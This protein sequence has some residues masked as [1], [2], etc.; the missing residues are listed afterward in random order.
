MPTPKTPKSKSKLKTTVDEANLKRILRHTHADPHGVLGCHVTPWGVVVRAYRP[1]ADTIFVVGGDGDEKPMEKTHPDGFFECVYADRK[2]VFSYRLRVTYGKESFLLEDPYRFLPTLGDVD[3]HLFNQGSHEELHDK[4]GAHHHVHEG[5]E[6]FSFAVWAPNAEGV[7]VV[8]DFNGWDGRLHLLRTMGAS[9]VWEIFIP[10]VQHGDHYKY[11]IHTKAGHLLLKTDPFA[12]ATEVPPGTAARTFRSSYPFQDAAWMEARKN[13]DS[14]REPMSIYELHL[15]SWKRK[16]DGQSLSYRELAPELA[17]YVKELGFTHVEL[18]P[19]MEHPFGGSW[20]YQV[21]AYFAPSARWGTPDDFKYFVDVMHQNGIG[22]ILDWVPAHFPKD[23]WALGRYDGSALFEHQDPREGEH[24]D[25]GTYVFNLGRHEVR[26]FLLSNA[27]FWL[28]H[29]HV[30]GLRIDAVASMLYR[31]YSRKEGEWIPNQFGGRENLEAIAFLKRLNEVV[32]GR[33]P[34][35]LVIAEES[36]AWPAVSRPT[37]AGGLGFG[38]K[39]NMGWMHD[40]LNYFSK[41]PIY[42]RYH[43]NDLTFGFL[44]AWSENFILPIS[45]DEVVHGKRS[46]IEKMP[47]D[48]W[49]RAANLRSL[50]AYMWAHPGKKLLFMGSEIGQW[51]EWN[52]DGALQWDLLQFKEHQGFKRLIGDLNQRMRENPALH[53]A[54]TDPA[55]F[56]WIDA[57]NADQNVAA[58]LRFSPTT[59]RVVACACNFSPEPRKDYRVGLPRGGFWKEILNTDS[60]VYGGSNVGNGGGVQAENHGWHGQPCSASVTL[61]PLGVVWFEAT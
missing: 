45:H 23:D 52:C 13:R 57:N 53:E 6:G 40:T 24:P 21:S 19:V 28:S 34:G 26:N 56:Q 30:D 31:D 58:F 44:Y 15:G 48:A 12:F 61:P 47:G 39:W 43:H 42:R 27:L 17:A 36:T 46:L 9:G 38:F 32:Y 3:L 37:Y 11:E 25:W 41:E 35:A 22:V 20:G 50:F 59:G 10:G 33:H 14:W 16:A 1:G 49:Q 51:H 8:G 5:V 2:E 4:F 29:F 54:D 7:S 18:M 55:G 60:E